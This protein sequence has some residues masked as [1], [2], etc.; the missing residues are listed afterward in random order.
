MRI[1]LSGAAF[2]AGTNR[3][4]EALLDGLDR[5]VENLDANDQSILKITYR[6][7]GE[8][9]EISNSRMV[10]VREL[11]RKQ[12]NGYRDQNFETRIVNGR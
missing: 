11:L 12:W 9:R 8:G 7:E 1:E 10:V 4:S 5:L 6:D 3:P 2:V